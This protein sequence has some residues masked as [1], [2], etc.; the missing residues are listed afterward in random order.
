MKVLHDAIADHTVL[1]FGGANL[2]V[3]AGRARG[4]DRSLRLPD[5]GA[6]PRDALML[7]L[8]SRYRVRLSIAGTGLELSA[9]AD[10]A[11]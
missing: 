2:A 7:L 9:R 11:A 6:G 1:S 3:G 10:E 5:L 4:R 8:A